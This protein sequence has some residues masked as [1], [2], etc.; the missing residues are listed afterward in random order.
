MSERRRIAGWVVTG[1]AC[2][3]GKERWVQN[4]TP[5]YA[6]N[7]NCEELL[8]GMKSWSGY[9]KVAYIEDSCKR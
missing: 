9:G 8:K 2:G 3:M 7:I 6:L 1:G 5:P 4:R